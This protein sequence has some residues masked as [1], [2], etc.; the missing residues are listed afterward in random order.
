MLSRMILLAS[1]L[2]KF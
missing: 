2:R 1:T